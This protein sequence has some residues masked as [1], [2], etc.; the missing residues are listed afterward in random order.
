MKDIYSQADKVIEKLKKSINA[1]FHNVK[2]E[3]AFDEIGE[4]SFVIEAADP[5]G[6]KTQKT[7]F[8]YVDT[9]P[10]L[11]FATAEKWVLAGTKNY[12]LLFDVLAIQEEVHRFAIDYH[13]SLRGKA[14]TRSVLDDI[15]GVGEKRKTAL[16]AKFGSIDNIKAATKYEIAETPGLNLKVAEEIEEYFKQKQ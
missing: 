13:R 5:S 7:A 4:H 6:N 8:V 12:D 2:N 15:S 11:L 14:L 16:L 3:I 1:E 10:E 9:P